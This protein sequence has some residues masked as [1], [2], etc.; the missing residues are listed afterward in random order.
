VVLY[1]LPNVVREMLMG[2]AKRSFGHMQNN[3]I[4]ISP[5]QY[6]D[7]GLYIF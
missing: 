7:F 5:I 3:V 4:A 2:V 1:W 6:F